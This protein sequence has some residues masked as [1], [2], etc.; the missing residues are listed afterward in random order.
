M[1]PIVSSD[2]VSP[3][4]KQS[5]F[6][7]LISDNNCTM[8]NTSFRMCE[9]ICDYVSELFYD[10]HLHAMKHGCSNALICDNPLYSFDTPVVLHEIDDD[11]EQVSDKE[12]MFIADTIAGFIA[13]GINPEDIAVLSPFRAQ[14]ANIRRVIRKHTGINK[15]DCKKYHLT[16]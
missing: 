14:A 11:G 4:L 2:K 6:E 13:K 1:P 8:L 3:R 10:G 9:P 12:A 7:A 5:A 16:Q 15:E